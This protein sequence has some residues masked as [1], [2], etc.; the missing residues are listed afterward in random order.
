MK[1]PRKSRAKA[2]GGGDSLG[3]KKIVRDFFE[4][5][6]QGRQKEGLRFFA[7]DCKQHN[8]YINGGMEALFEGMAAAQKGAPKYPDPHFAIKSVLADGD[9]VA[10]HTA[11]LS[12]KSK[13]SEGGLRQVH[14]FRFNKGNKIVEYWDISQ[15][16]QPD[17]PN[18]SGAF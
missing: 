15:M 7:P 8:P 1:M 12:S 10:V 13:P 2:A 9:L 5:V 11:L 17:M 3:R 4:L 6:M 18:A 14:L 16:V